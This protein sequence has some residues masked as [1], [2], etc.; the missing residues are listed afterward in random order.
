MNTKI[1]LVVI[2]DI[3]LNKKELRKTR[4]LKNFLANCNFNITY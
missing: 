4:K 2:R 1:A 3:G